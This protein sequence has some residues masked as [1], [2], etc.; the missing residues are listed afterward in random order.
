VAYINSLSL[1]SS[2]GSE[3]NCVKPQDSW[4]AGRDSKRV[5]PNTMQKL[6][7]L[8]HLTC[9]VTGCA[10]LLHCIAHL[11]RFVQHIL[12]FTEILCTNLKKIAGKNAVGAFV[13]YSMEYSV[14]SPAS[15]RLLTENVRTNYCKS[16]KPTFR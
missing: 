12:C 9:S 15:L 1:R 6:Y 14:A 4:C 11:A 16:H 13:Y 8:K 3:E 7:R 10:S 2:G 5:L